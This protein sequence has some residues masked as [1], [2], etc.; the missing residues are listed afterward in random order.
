[1]NVFDEVDQALADV[2]RIRRIWL[3]EY[4]RVN[5]R[6]S[7]GPSADDI[8]AARHGVTR[9]EILNRQKRKKC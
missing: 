8:A 7:D 3:Q 5:R 2:Q 6:K 1:M 4:F 9:N